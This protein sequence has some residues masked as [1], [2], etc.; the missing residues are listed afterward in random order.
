MSNR[1]VPSNKGA[2]SLA[3][4]SYRH[5]KGGTVEVLGVA[6]HSE[7]LEELV[8]YKCSYD[9]STFGKGSIWVRPLS[10]F[11]EQVVVNEKRV[12]RFVLI[13][14]GTGEVDAARG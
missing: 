5:Y 11:L 7:T 6:H 8:V 12:P 14:D 3:L 2:R 1:E 4:G 13:T 10:M 9:C